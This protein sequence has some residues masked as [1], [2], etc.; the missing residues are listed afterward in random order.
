MPYAQEPN[1]MRARNLKP[2]FF[3]NE[4]L[5]GV[6]HT[7]RLLF[8]GLSLVADREGRF[9]YRPNKIRLQVF[10]G[11][12]PVLVDIETRFNELA[13]QELI[14]FY[15]GPNGRCYGWIPTFTKHQTPHHRESPSV[16][17]P[18]PRLNGHDDKSLGRVGASPG[19]APPES[20][21]PESLNPE[22]R[23]EA[24][25][26]A[27]VSPPSFALDGNPPDPSRDKIPY[28]EIRK[29]YN[30]IC[31]DLPLCKQL[32]TM[33]RKQIRGRWVN[34]LPSLDRWEKFFKYIHERC[35]FLNGRVG[36]DRPFRA[37]FTWLT[38]EANYIKIRE[39]KYEQ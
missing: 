23:E 10:P 3:H 13:Q 15:D 12:D 17:P 11:D 27:A 4:Q 28:E 6:S 24:A 35:P 36:G 9:E 34:D 7:A 30:R 18:P 2:G 37:D 32:G 16:L 33:R 22:S 26:N 21:N 20:L 5:A 29:L 8:A 1:E 31:T 39:R 14:E 25:A 38:K 19:L